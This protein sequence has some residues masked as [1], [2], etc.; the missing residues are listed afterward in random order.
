MLIMETGVIT[1]TITMINMANTYIALIQNLT[2]NGQEKRNMTNTASTN[3]ILAT[4]WMTMELMYGT[5]R[6]LTTLNGAID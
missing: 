3:L 1:T 6:E 5:T 2:L 4:T